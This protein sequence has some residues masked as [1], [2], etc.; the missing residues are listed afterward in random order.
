MT[1]SDIQKMMKWVIVGIGCV[2]GIACLAGKNPV[3]DV[4]IDF[5]E[6]EAGTTVISHDYA[7]VKLDAGKQ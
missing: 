6:L 5:N 3:K 2:L 7:L 4:C 1:I